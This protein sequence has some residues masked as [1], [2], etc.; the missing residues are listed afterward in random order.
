MKRHSLVRV[1]LAMGLLLTT[2]VSH[3]DPMPVRIETRC[4]DTSIEYKLNDHAVTEVRKSIAH[5][6][7]NNDSAVLHI[8][9]NAVPVRHGFLIKKRLDFQ[10]DR[11]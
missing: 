10:G 11:G 8:R 6:L 7:V 1:L 3:A 9:L 4:P 2:K 5:S